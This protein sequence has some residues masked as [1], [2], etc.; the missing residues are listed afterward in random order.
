M[1]KIYEDDHF[2]LDRKTSFLYTTL[3]ADANVGG[4]RHS[5]DRGNVHKGILQQR[6]G[7]TD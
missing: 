2:Y 7:L 6:D 5:T 1:A 4:F 3:V